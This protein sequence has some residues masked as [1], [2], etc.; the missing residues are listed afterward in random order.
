MENKKFDITSTVLEKGIDTAKSFLDKL[1]MPAIEETGLLLKDQVT[2]WKFKNQ[3]RMLNKAKLHCEK[4][5]ISPK[6]I[7]LKLLCPLLDYSGLEEDEV[8]HD[9]WAILLS[10]MVDSEQNIENHVFPYILSQLSSNEFLVLE[11][12]YDEKI[13]RV[14]MLTKELSEFKESRSQIEKEL[15]KKLETI[16]IQIQQI[17]EI[18]KNHFNDEIWELQK[19]RRKIEGQQSSIKYKESGLNYQIR[20]PETIPYDSLK[21]FEL[22]NVIRLGLVKEEKEFYANSQTL[23]IPNDR[24]YDRSYINVDLDIH[25]ESNTDNILTELG[26][27]F[28]NAC[29]DKQHKNSL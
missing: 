9:K 29:K 4:N 22:S 26:E 19:E 3:V 27:L 14:A 25:V 16:D 1:I 13:A 6:T 20:K 18:T 23:E 7:S 2:M 17:K 21:E 12:V 8:L 15:E 10:N 24:E 28:I 5:K 11:K